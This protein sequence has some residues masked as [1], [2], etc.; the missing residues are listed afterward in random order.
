MGMCGVY[1]PGMVMAQRRW[2]V[3]AVSALLLIHMRHSINWKSI[4]QQPPPSRPNLRNNPWAYPYPS[5]P[6]AAPAA[7][8]DTTRRPPLSAKQPAPQPSRRDRRASERATENRE[9]F[10]AARA[11]RRNRPA[12]SG[13]S[14]SGSSW[15]NTRTMT[16][17][18]IGIGILVVI[19]VAISQFSGTTKLKDPGVV[20][21]P[22]LISGATLGKADAPVT[23]EVYGDF[24]C[25]FCALY[26]LNVEPVIVNKYVTPGIARIVHH[27]FEFI[28]QGTADRESRLASAGAVCAVA[29]DKYWDYAHWVFNNQIGEN[30]GAFKRDR[31][32]A[33]AAAAGLDTAAFGTC[34]ND[35]ATLAAVD[36][37]TADALTVKNVVS[38]PTV[39]I[40][41]VSVDWGSTVKTAD[42]L[43]TL[44]E[45]AAQVKASAS[46]SVAPSASAS[47]T[48]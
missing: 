41:G 33:I 20:Y 7:H 47:T 26:D 3:A 14:S 22:S 30:V 16:I 48:P 11:D 17:A 19:L 35:A 13:G 31:L 36:A 40:N 18:G 34:L 43:G 38:T 23:V 15:L 8:R 39:L 9:R 5:N 44:I 25:P 24:Q 46:P 10:E 45:V 2:N 29:Q 42:Q 4:G 21:A 6:R 12:S 32:V 37:A 1:A 28:G 27:D